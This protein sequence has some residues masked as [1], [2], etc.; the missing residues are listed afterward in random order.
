M[1]LWRDARQDSSPRRATGRPLLL[2]LAG[3]SAQPSGP[4]TGA[5]YRP[6]RPSRQRR[7][8]PIGGAPSGQRD[9]DQPRDRARTACTDMQLR[10][11]PLRTRYRQVYE[12]GGRLRIALR[13]R[14]TTTYY[15]LAITIPER[16]T[17]PLHLPFE[18]QPDLAAIGRRQRARRAIIV[19][20][21]HKP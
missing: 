7:C 17:I 14:M 11:C 12:L 8:S 20:E 10:S 6:S 5:Q 19:C 4:G 13:F 9:E 3:R 16:E 1:R 18:T 21:L 15:R 2:P